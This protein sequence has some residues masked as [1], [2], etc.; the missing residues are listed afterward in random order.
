VVDT[1]YADAAPFGSSHF[2]VDVRSPQGD[3]D[4]TVRS[5][6]V[7]AGFFDVMG[8]PLLGGRG[9]SAGDSARG[10]VIVDALFVAQ[11]FGGVDPVGRSIRIANDDGYREATVIGVVP[12]VKF[13][14]LDEPSVQAALYEVLRAPSEIH[15]RLTRIRGAP[16]DLVDGVR[17]AVLQAAPDAVLAY[18]RPLAEAVDASVAGRF[19]LLQLVGLFALG[20]LLLSGLGLYA[21]LGLSVLER[22]PE[23]G[24]RLALG[25]TGSRILGLVL[26][27][28]LRLLL[29]GV[30]LGV[31]VG[32]VAAGWL[33]DDLFRV[34]PHDLAA[35]LLAALAIGVV[36][37]LACALPARR[38]A[39][40][41]PRLAIDGG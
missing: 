16:A 38:A 19:A 13:R 33:A 28:G 32:I 27:Q 30:L 7:S 2:I 18:H 5:N 14:S 26:N 39:R 12:T 8:M 3:A 10:E 36:A 4:I 15:F 23:F 29:P 11:V 40:V 31:L 22:R 17:A 6:G 24:V 9:F 1:A 35:W 41:S 21:V 25:A 20:V 34:A 37:L